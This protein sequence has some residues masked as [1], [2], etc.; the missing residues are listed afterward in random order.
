MNHNSF[1]SSTKG[2]EMLKHLLFVLREA[3]LKIG[4][5]DCLDPNSTSLLTGCNLSRLGECTKNANKHN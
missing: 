5:Q 2:M 1:G 3:R 4:G